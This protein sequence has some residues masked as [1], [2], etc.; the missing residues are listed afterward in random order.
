MMGSILVALLFVS[1][2]ALEKREPLWFSSEFS[3]LPKPWHPEP[4]HLIASNPV[5]EP[6]VRVN[7]TAPPAVVTATNAA[8]AAP[9]PKSDPIKKRV[10]RKHPSPGEAKQGAI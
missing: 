5:W 10:A 3:G 9:T 8:A 6:D 7:A 2:A 1:D 4:L